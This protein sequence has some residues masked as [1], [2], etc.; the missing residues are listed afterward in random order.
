MNDL[1]QLEILVNILLQSLG[2][3]LVLPMKAISF[4]GT[5]EFY[6]LLIPLIFWCVDPGAGFK[7]GLILLF[8][9]GINTP[10]KI[11]FHQPRPYWIDLRV[12][13]V[14]PESSFGVPS[15]HSQIS[16]SIWGFLASNTRRSWLFILYYAAILLIGISRIYLGVHFLS[17]VIAGWALGGAV[18]ILFI[19][20]ERPAVNWLKNASFARLEMIAL[21]GSILLVL[22]TVL[23]GLALAN[24]PIPADWVSNIH[25]ADPLTVIDPF[26]VKDGFTVGGIWLGL[27]SGYAWLIRK[28]KIFSAQGTLLQK[29]LRYSCGLVGVLILFLGLKLFLPGGNDLVSYLLRYL[30]YALIGLWIT[31]GAPWMFRKLR[32]IG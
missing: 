3:W 17:D 6:V 11:L 1:H 15:G 16:A 24:W 25:A 7:T 21:L 29:S 22:L 30:R 26:A 12:Q 10:L 31:A 5:E 4:L 2:S 28:G 23:P 13:A 32:L 14:T 18:L 9:S 20:L 8:T 27:V 19:R